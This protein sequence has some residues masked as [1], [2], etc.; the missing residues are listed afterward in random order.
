MKLPVNRTWPLAAVA[1]LTACGGSASVKDVPA[2]AA[3]GPAADYPMVLGAPFTVDGTT[4]TPVDTM[5]FDTVGFASSGSD[6]GS[7]VSAAHRT[8]P[9]PSYV[10]VT[11]LS[12]GKTILVRVE[13]RGPM[14]GS[15]IIELSPGAIAQIGF[16]GA[17]NMPVRVRRVNPPEI[18][19]ALLRTGQIAPPRMD[20]PKSLLAVLQRKLDLQ[21]G[22]P[23][24]PVLADTVP[25]GA[26]SPAPV[27]NSQVQTQPVS[28]P[29]AMKPVSKP[30]GTKAEPPTKP[31]VSSPVKPATSRLVTGSWFVQI[32]TFASKANADAAAKK[33]GALVSASGKLWRVRMGPFGDADKARPALAKAKSAGYSDARIQRAD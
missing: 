30:A 15:S 1:L 2:P 22:I 32:G 5:N 6:G 3:N 7:S 24:K 14:F 27:N 26:A 20:T 10:E 29:V 21:M 12:T 9:L 28:Q 17:S 25:D 31:P 33:A 11:S 19:R 16:A 8:L 18:E 23:A 4:Y 13:R